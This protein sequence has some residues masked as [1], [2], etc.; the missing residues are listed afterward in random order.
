MIKQ[1]HWIEKWPHEDEKIFE[2][3]RVWPNDDVRRE[4][5]LW[6]NTFGKEWGENLKKFINPEGCEPKKCSVL[7][8]PEKYDS[9]FLLDL[10]YEALSFV[11]VEKRWEVTFSTFATEKHKKLDWLWT[12]V[13]L[14]DNAAKR[15]LISGDAYIHLR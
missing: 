10:F 11:P 9:D 4:P 6:Q 5:M 14:Y 8:D 1:H 7:F 13:N 3:T 15:D 2:P 12:G